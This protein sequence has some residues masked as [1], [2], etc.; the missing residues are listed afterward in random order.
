MDAMKELTRREKRR[1]ET[2]EE[3]LAI[4]REE[5]RKRGVAGLRLEMIAKRVGMRT[6]SLYTY[7]ESKDA[8]YDELFRRGFLA[9][10]QLMTEEVG[11]AG[12][13]RE[14]LL[15]SIETY[16]RFAQENPEL[17][18]LMFQ[19]PV[20]GFVPSEES[21]AV[22]LANVALAQA[23]FEAIFRSGELETDLPVDE[24]RDLCF[25]LQHGL[26]EL[27]LANNPDKP[28]GEGRYGKLTAQSVQLLLD[29]WRKS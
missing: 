26:T 18:Q 9:F 1:Q 2:V 28:V 27:H 25:A 6:P 13:A 15:R 22:S 4:A 7:F 23:E 14:K 21:M 19:R 24:A 20:P 10:G 5:M 29:A 3:I 16:M 17:Y 8:I 11:R 12:S